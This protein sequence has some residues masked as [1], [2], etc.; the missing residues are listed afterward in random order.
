MRQSSLAKETERRRAKKDAATED[1]TIGDTRLKVLPNGDLDA[2]D[3]LDDTSL[4]PIFREA[5]R[6]NLAVENAA[7][8]RRRKHAKKHPR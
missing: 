6:R 1:A 3:I 7:R 8:R 4:S 5:F 2:S